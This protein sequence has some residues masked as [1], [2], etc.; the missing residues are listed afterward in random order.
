MGRRADAALRGSFDLSIWVRSRPRSN[1]A[2]QRW[3]WIWRS[4]ISSMSR[5]FAFLIH[6]RRR[7]FPC[8][9]APPTYER[10]CPVNGSG[11]WHE[12]ERKGRNG[13]YGN[14][15]KRST[16][17][18]SLGGRIVLEQSD[19]AS[20]KK[21]LNVVAAQLPLTSIDADVGVT[22][23]LLAAFDRPGRACRSLLR[24]RRCFLG[25]RTACRT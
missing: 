17:T 6:A 18:W 22:K 25:R 4:L 8:R 12:R 1:S 9:T 24:R 16:R 13:K 11:L 23:N 10:G 19:P 15:N 21:G 14:E 7:E 20:Q 2:D 3:S 5:P